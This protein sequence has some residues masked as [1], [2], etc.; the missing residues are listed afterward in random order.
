MNPALGQNCTGLLAGYY[1]CVGTPMNVTS[2]NTT[3]SQSFPAWTPPTGGTATPQI[4][5][6]LVQSGVI[7]DCVGFYQAQ[8]ISI[9]SHLKQR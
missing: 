7:T 6:S 1:V 4:T 9:E 2:G 3:V 5:P 8:T